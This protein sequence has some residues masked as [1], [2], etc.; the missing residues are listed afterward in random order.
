[1]TIRYP[2]VKKKRLREYFIAERHY[3]LLRTS[4]AQ[5]RKLS[6]AVG[7]CPRVKGFESKEREC[8]FREVGRVYSDVLRTAV[9]FPEYTSARLPP[10]S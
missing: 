10:I 2:H 9:N 6:F 8:I 5:L 4:S 1:M 3:N 7:F